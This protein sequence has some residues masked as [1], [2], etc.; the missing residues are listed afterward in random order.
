MLQH[1]Q[2]HCKTARTVSTVKSKGL[3]KMN[4]AVMP[5]AYQKSHLIV[6]F[7]NIHHKAQIYA[8]QFRPKGSIKFLRKKKN[9][10]RE[11]L[12][13]N[14]NKWDRFSFSALFKVSGWCS[15]LVSL[16]VCLIWLKISLIFKKRA[17]T[18][19][20]ETS[21]FP[22]IQ[23]Q[24]SH[25]GWHSQPQLNKSFSSYAFCEVPKDKL[26]HLFRSRLQC[27][28]GNLFY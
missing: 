11:Y 14:N 19:F 28:G 22:V 3:V 25:L 12:L 17:M 2:L 23:T 5:W 13:Y 18:Q 16:I 27:T 1:F 20:F 4:L 21:E 26:Q 6:T 10:L 15:L 9:I 24:P 8:I 7:R